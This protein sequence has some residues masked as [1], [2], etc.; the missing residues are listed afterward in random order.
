MKKKKK[1]DSISTGVKVKGNKKIK[2]TVNSRK[3][4]SIFVLRIQ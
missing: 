3:Y 1:I 2:I 4:S